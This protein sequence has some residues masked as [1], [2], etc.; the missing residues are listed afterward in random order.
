MG[1]QAVGSYT[2]S[3]SYFIS[4]LCTDGPWENGPEQGRPQVQGRTV[5]RQTFGKHHL[6]VTYVTPSAGARGRRSP[7]ESGAKASSCTSAKGVEESPLPCQL[8]PRLEDSS[9][10]KA[11]TLSGLQC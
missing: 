10:V 5:E 2:D 7:A 4:D 6:P 1:E 11:V 8:A 3:I 9:K